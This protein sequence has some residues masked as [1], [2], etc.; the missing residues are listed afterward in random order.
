MLW[1][2]LS[3]LTALAV[4]SQ[5]AWVK[6]HFSHLTAYDMLAFPFMFSLP[7]F[8]IAVPFI[9]V[10]PLD[11]T[12]YWSFLISL[13]LNFIPFFIYMKAI[14]T[15][16]LSGYVFLGEIPNTWGLAGIVITCIGGYVL[17]LESGR[18]SF[19]APIKAVFKETGSWLMLIVALLFSFSA[20]I[21]KKGILHSSPLFFTMTFFAA[22][23]FLTLVVLLALGK[24]HLKTF[25]D[26][27]AKGMVAGALFFVHALSHGFAISMV[28]ASYMISVKRLS[29]LIGI[30]YG[31][32]FFN[33][34]YVAVRLM[35]AG[36]MVAGAV[37]ITIWGK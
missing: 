22:L 17:N 29:A 21:G 5:D 13:P 6:K 14:R 33:E 26:D 36:L 9:P 3:L 31:G 12:F 2:I 16:P 7:L 15:S 25:R 10:P 27:W 20:V 18:H 1:L 23:S 4:A 32:L 37:L 30:I 11:D 28:K 8:V 19:G 34:K 24:I 35:G